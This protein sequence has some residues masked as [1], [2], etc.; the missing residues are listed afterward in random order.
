MP[1]PPDFLLFAGFHEQLKQGNLI[2][3]REQGR[4]DDTGVQ[5]LLELVG[6]A[7]PNRPSRKFLLSQAEYACA[8]SNELRSNLAG[9]PDMSRG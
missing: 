4:V 3:R 1:P 7:S 5:E 6:H 2:L 9:I 8:V